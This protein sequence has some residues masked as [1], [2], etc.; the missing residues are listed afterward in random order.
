MKT[1]ATIT[2]FLFALCAAAQDSLQ[3]QDHTNTPSATKW[4]VRGYIKQLNAVALD[5]QLRYIASTALLH[6]RLNLR[7]KPEEKWSAALELRNRVLWGDELRLIP[8]YTNLLRNTSEWANLQ[9][10]WVS[11]PGIIVHTNVERLWLQWQTQRLTLRAG[12][13]RINW[14]VTTNWNPND[15]FNTFNFL[16]FD[17]E[18]RPGADAVSLQYQLKGDADLELAASGNGHVNGQVVALRYHFNRNAYDYYLLAGWF[19]NQPTV[20]AAWAGSINDAGFKGE[21]Q[22]FPAAAGATATLNLATELDYVFKKG[23]YFNTGLLYTSRGTTAEI[24]NLNLPLFRFSP[25]NL[26]PTRWNITATGMKEISTLFS[27]SCTFIFAPGTDLL[28]L[29]PSVRYNL[30]QNIDADFFCQSFLAGRQNRLRAQA[31]RGFLRIRWS[32]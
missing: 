27:A 3:I 12:R 10:A 29:L 2:L 21:L 1:P 16:D 24:S 5:P 30:A 17:Y 32:F 11:Q 18:E 15:L 19:N 23:W 6:N 14:G 25:K 7:W 8:D 9:K 28:L 20:G 22:W 13:Q 31:T 26:M 4:E